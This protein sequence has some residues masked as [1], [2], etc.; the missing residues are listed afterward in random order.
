MTRKRAAL[1]ASWRAR[2]AKAG[3]P[4]KRG[5]VF[6]AMPEREIRQ[7]QVSAPL[8]GAQMSGG[9]ELEDMING[10]VR[11]ALLHGGEAIVSPHHQFRI[12][13]RLDVASPRGIKF[14]RHHGF[15]F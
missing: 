5:S 9:A 1:G 8:V 11:D 12:R 6:S 15:L 10:L 3:E 14:L 4:T 13:R 2:A 7:F